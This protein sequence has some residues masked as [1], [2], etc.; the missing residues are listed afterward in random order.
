MG[1]KPP[2]AQELYRAR[3]Q[4]EEEEREA[5]LPPGLVNHGNTCFMNSVLQGVSEA[6]FNLRISLTSLMLSISI[7]QHEQLIATPMLSDIVRFSLPE[8]HLPICS[9]RSPQLTNGH[10][11]GGEWEKEW[12]PS[13]PLGDVF[14]AMMVRAWECQEEQRRINLTPR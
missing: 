12:E 7:R 9:R 5:L 2:T 14:T 3:K 10:E 1:K 8:S 11:R 4:K 13:M 6:R